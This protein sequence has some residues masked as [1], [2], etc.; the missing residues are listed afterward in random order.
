MSVHIQTFITMK[1]SF[2]LK[3]IQQYAL[4]IKIM[5]LKNLEG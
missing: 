5:V 3:K 2:F 1:A 4:V